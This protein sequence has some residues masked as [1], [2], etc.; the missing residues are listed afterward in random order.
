MRVSVH[1]RKEVCTA[2]TR[3]GAKLCGQ[4]TITRAD[5]T[6]V[7]IS[8]PPF[9]SRGWGGG[10]AGYVL[11]LTPQLGASRPDVTPPQPP[12]LSTSMGAY[13]GPF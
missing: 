8:I 7:S 12:C 9:L 1:V 11:D 2:V 4:S 13:P 10:S 6:Q 3:H 5:R